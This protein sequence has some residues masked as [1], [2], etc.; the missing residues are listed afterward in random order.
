[1]D[2]KIPAP[3]PVIEEPVSKP[4]VEDLVENGY[5]DFIN[6]TRFIYKMEEGAMRKLNSLGNIFFQAI[7]SVVISRNLTDSLCGTKVFKKE[8]IEKLFNWKKMLKVSDPFGDFD[9]IF[10]AAY[11]G[12]KIT[13]YPV[14]YK[15]RVYGS[16]QIS[17]FRDG[18]R[19]LFYFLNSIFVFHTS[20]D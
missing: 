12:Y 1:M 11:F 20:N 9:L 5:A 17:R 16:T 10:T 8:M 18:V 4:V 14:H 6:G 7:I 19:P 3:E 15:S 13:E 2:L